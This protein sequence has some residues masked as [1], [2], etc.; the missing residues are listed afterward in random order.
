MFEETFRGTAEECIAHFS[1]KTIKGEIVMVL[2]GK[3]EE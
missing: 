2:E 1:A 3:P